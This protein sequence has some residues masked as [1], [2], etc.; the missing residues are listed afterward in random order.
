MNTS[1]QIYAST[2]YIQFSETWPTQEQLGREHILLL[3]LNIRIKIN[4][5]KTSDRVK[6]SKLCVASTTARTVHDLTY[7]GKIRFSPVIVKKTS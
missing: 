2:T 4:K 1:S 5:N 7:V 6:F 3:F